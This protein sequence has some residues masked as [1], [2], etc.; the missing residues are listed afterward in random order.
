MSPNLTFQLV[1]PTSVQVTLQ[2]DQQYMLDTSLSTN[3]QIVVDLKLTNNIYSGNVD[4]SGLTF[5]NLIYNVG[6]NQPAI[7]Q[8]V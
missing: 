2:K 8:G 1:S 3:F 4:S 7:T 6:F 5:Q